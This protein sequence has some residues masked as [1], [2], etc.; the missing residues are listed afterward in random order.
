M[1]EE[2]Y[3]CDYFRKYVTD[4]IGHKPEFTNNWVMKLGRNLL[5][6]STGYVEVFYCPWCGAKLNSPES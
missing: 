6:F 3:C 1:T 2:K 5:D 4:I